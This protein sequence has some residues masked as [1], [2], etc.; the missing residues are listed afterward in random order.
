MQPPDSLHARLDRLVATTQAEQRSPSVVAAVVRDGETIW[1]TLIDEGGM[2]GSAFSSPFKA[3]LAGKTQLLVQTR[4][5]LCG[6]DPA[7]GK[8]LWSK[9]IAGMRGMNILTPTVY[10]D[11]VFISAYG[12]KSY[13]FRVVRDGGKWAV[14]TAWSLN[15]D[16]NMSSPVVVG[17]YAYLHRRDQRLSCIDLETGRVKW[18]TTRTFGKYWSLA[19]RGDKLLALDQ[20]GALYLIKANPEKF[21]LLD[22]RRV[23]RQ[24]TWGHLAVAGGEI[25]VRELKGVVSYRWAGAE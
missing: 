3:T 10:K 19:V 4:K 2:W 11:S 25:Y 12:A 1:R 9:P 7:T 6:V 15:F 18:T 14:E 21:E 16:A 13:R 5:K 23:S 22:E 24:E 20:R 17:R 8:E